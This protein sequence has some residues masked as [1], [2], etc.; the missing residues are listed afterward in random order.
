MFH[1]PVGLQAPAEIDG[2][3]GVP[4]MPA[5]EQEGPDVPAGL[6]AKHQHPT[7]G[8]HRQPPSHDQ[9]LAISNINHKQT[10]NSNHQPTATITQQPQQ[11]TS[12]QRVTTRSNHQQPTAS[13]YCRPLS[14]KSHQQLVC[15]NRHQV[16]STEQS[17]AS[18]VA[19]SRWLPSWS[20]ALPARTGTTTDAC[21]F[22]VS[23]GARKRARK[24]QREGNT[25]SP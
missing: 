5:S 17:I 21:T 6:G 14:A 4:N 9:S 15:N 19:K 1:A 8:S 22:K 23:S 10:A 25:R 16:S 7:G 13:N 2:A 11:A 18:R 12:N 20:S 24:G 3:K